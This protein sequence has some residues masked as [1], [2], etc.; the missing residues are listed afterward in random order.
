MTDTELQKKADQFHR[1][2]RQGDAGTAMQ[3]LG[4]AVVEAERRGYERGKAETAAP[5]APAETVDVAEVAE[6]VR[7]AEEREPILEDE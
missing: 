6:A 7:A 3:L 5:P 4:E 1:A 2:V